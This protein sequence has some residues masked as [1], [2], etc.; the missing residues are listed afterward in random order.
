MLMVMVYIKA[1]VG[2][3]KDGDPAKQFT[4]EYFDQ[5][6]NRFVRSGGT[7]AWRCNNPG[8]LHASHYSTSSRRRCIG[9]AGDAK[10]TYAVYPD[11]QTGH[12]ALVVMLRG[13]VYSPRTL[14]KAMFH[15]DERNL[16]Y[17]DITVSKTNLDPERTIKSLNDKEFERFWRAIEETEKWVKGV[18][19]PKPLNHVIGVHKK[20]GVICEYC[21]RQK[22]GD[23]WLSKPDAIALAQDGTLHV[24]V[25]HVS[26]GNLYLRPVFHEK[27]FREIVC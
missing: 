27:S 8:N 4:V 9:T 21:I 26:N 6:G 23:V 7:R 24:I 3:A 17:I 20:R 1:Q 12:E 14:R 11:Y 5:E 19:E 10:D 25:V 16:K 2:L 13:T 18:E 15:Y 22:N